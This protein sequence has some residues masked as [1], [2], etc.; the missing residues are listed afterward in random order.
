M[1]CLTRCL[2]YTEHWIKCSYYYWSR[3]QKTESWLSP[4]LRL[5]RGESQ[6]SR[7]A[8]V[9]EKGK[10]HEA[11]GRRIIGEGPAGQVRGWGLRI[12]QKSDGPC[13]QECF[14]HRAKKVKSNSGIEPSLWADSRN[15]WRGKDRL[16]PREEVVMIALN[17]EGEQNHRMEDTGRAVR[18]G[19]RRVTADSGLRAQGMGHRVLR[20]STQGDKC[21]PHQSDASRYQ[22]RCLCILVRWMDFAPVDS[23]N[24]FSNG[25]GQVKCPNCV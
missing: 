12:Q 7:A 10:L 3:K 16:F 25:S 22:G 6:E 23:L 4:Q 17:T 1:K 11:E 19:R 8:A 2:A 24:L 15:E 20:S 5:A 18:M 21:I 13:Y 14:F 9:G